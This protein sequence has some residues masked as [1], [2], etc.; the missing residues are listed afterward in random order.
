MARER[1]INHDFATDR[2]RL[3]YAHV[4]LYDVHMRRLWIA[5]KRFGSNPAQVSHARLIT[6]EA[7]GSA[8]EKDRFLCFWFHPPNTG[9]GLVQ[10]QSLDWREGHLMVRLDPYWDHYNQR[11]LAPTE[12]AYV[13]H[14]L[15]QQ[16]RWG[17]RIFHAYVTKTRKFPLTWHMI[18]PRAED[19][20]F[21]VERI[22]PE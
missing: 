18:G 4:G 17:Q 1:A 15:N 14:N 6:G 19:S 3:D 20:M 7:D 5:R 11:F 13:E 16:Y 2:L 8:V 10:G 12:R 9:E 21:H 22:E